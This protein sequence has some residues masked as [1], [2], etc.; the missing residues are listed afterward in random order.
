[1]QR[2]A[3]ARALISEPAVLLADEPTGNLDAS[4]GGEVMETLHGLREQENLTIIMVTHD[5]QLAASADRV[6]HLVNGKVA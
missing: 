5:D 4:N 6:I 1:M 2:T 3:I